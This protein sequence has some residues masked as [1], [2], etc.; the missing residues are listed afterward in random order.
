MVFDTIEIDLVLFGIKFFRHRLLNFLI[1]I[2]S[3]LGITFLNVF[4]G[5]NSSFGA[6][7]VGGMFFGW[8]PNIHVS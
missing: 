8:N 2:I 5:I 4:N 3:S 1:G 7:E 6:E